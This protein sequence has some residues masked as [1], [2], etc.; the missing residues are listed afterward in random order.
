MARH[1]GAELH[2]INL[3]DPMMT[4][5]MLI[6]AVQGDGQGVYSIYL[7]KGVE[8]VVQCRSMRNDKL[9]YTTL[10]NVLDGPFASTSGAINIITCSNFDHFKEDT[11]SVDALLRAGRIAERVQFPDS[12]Q[13]ED[14]FAM[15]LGTSSAAADEQRSFT[16]FNKDNSS[17][18]EARPSQFASEENSMVKAAA[19]QFQTNWLDCFAPPTSTLQHPCC[20]FTLYDVKNYLS[21]F[22]T[23][24][25]PWGAEISARYKDRFKASTCL[26]SR[27]LLD[28]IPAAADLTLAFVY[29]P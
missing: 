22:F 20:A 2:I 13:L 27:P 14:M 12:P 19:T 3:D 4:D 1:L 28:A 18:V 9:T 11:L 10:L 5:G 15:M 26:L 16:S 6:D 25:K 23:G 7:F 21:Q 29:C 8:R 17:L 24:Q